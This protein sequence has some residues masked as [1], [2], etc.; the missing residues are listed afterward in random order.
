MSVL[1]EKR[2]LQSS[3]LVPAKK[4]RNELMLSSGGQANNAIVQKVYNALTSENI[5]MLYLN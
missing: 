3:A 5:N 1:A 4:P 2:R